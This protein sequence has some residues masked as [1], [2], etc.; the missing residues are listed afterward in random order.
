M[1]SVPDDQASRL[2]LKFLDKIDFGTDLEQS[3]N[4]YGE[5]RA[6]FGHF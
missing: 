1:K 3:L 4:F 2:A 5:M 6:C